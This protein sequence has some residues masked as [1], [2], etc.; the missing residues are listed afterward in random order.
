[1]IKPKTEIGDPALNLIITAQ[2]RTPAP[3]QR[4]VFGTIHSDTQR[5]THVTA[6]LT[7]DNDKVGDT[8][9]FCKVKALS[10]PRLLCFNM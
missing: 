4:T 2:S 9:H 5:G 7:I 10:S 1:M 6:T 8:P 3:S